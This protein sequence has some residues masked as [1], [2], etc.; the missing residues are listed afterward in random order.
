MASPSC[1]R[2]FVHCARRAA[3][4]AACTAGK[5]RAISTAMIAMTTRS[6]MSVKPERR[7]DMVI[8][9]PSIYA[10][11]MEDPSWART[12]PGE[13]KGDDR[14]RSS[15]DRTFASIKANTRRHHLARGCT[16]KRRRSQR[17][18]L[19]AL[20][21]RRI[22]ATRPDLLRTDRRSSE[23]VPGVKTG[24]VGGNR[25]RGI[26]RPELPGDELDGMDRI[27]ARQAVHLAAA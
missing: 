25:G 5:S 11:K 16:G 23:Y 7:S 14:H 24:R 10:A 18:H 8:P 27:E 20:G 9:T 1:L 6:S 12:H 22:D 17:H 15:G 19:A 2:L 3:S 26:A 21:I 13:E 4:R